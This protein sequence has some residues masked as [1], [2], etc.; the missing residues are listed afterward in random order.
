MR[1]PIGAINANRLEDSKDF[2]PSYQDE[3]ISSVK[4]SNDG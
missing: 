2:E 4:K 1:R 3:E